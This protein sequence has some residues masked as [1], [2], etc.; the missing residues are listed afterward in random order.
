MPVVSKADFERL[1]RLRAISPDGAVLYPVSH[2]GH[3]YAPGG[4]SFS[5]GALPTP[6]TPV[7]VEPVVPAPTA[8]EPVAETVKPAPAPVKSEPKPHR[9]HAKREVKAGQHPALEDEA[10]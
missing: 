9:S 10:E 2:S 8:P 5:V 7:A 6:P 4:E 1:L 3:S